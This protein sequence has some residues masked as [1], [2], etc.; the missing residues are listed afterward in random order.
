MDRKVE[1]EEE[2]DWLSSILVVTKNTDRK[3]KY[4]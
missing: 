3:E 2:I 4:V 1:R